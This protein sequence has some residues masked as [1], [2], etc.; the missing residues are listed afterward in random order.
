MVNH[1]ELIERMGQEQAEV[2][3]AV[4]FADVKGQVQAKRALEVAVAG[5]HNLLMSGPPGSGKSLL[6][7]A[8]LSILPPMDMDEILEV[9]RIYSVSGLLPEEGGV[10]VQRPFR[11]PHHSASM[12]GLCGGGSNPRSGEIT[13]AHRGVLFLDELVEFPRPVLEVLRQPLENAEI[14]I[15]RAKQAYTFPAR[16]M[17]IG[18]MNPCPCGYHGDDGNRCT[19]SPAHVERYR[20]RLSGPLLDRIDVQLTV[21][22]LSTEELLFNSNE[23]AVPVENSATIKERVTQARRLQ[24][25]RFQDLGVSHLKS[26]AEMA[27]AQVKAFCVLDDPCQGLM[28]KAIER[29]NLSARGYDRMLRL[30][31]TIADLAENQI[32]YQFYNEAA[33]NHQIH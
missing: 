13:L 33:Q 20:A 18:A 27:P 16:F 11:S 23:N 24:V 32:L 12:A 22:R 7:K 14:T 3:N 5:G 26:N 17:L 15:S 28:R 6:A 25:K 1:A 30:A 21:R 19:C 8:L 2:L 29:L 31:R 10:I 4:D 9:S